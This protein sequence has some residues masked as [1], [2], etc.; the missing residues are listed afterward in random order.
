MEQAYHL[1]V[2]Q[3]FLKVKHDAYFDKV[4]SKYRKRIV[5][6]ED[7][8]FSE[9]GNEVFLK[10]ID[11]LANALF[12]EE[13]AKWNEYIQPIL[14]S[15]DCIV[16]PKSVD[17]TTELKNDSKDCAHKN[18]TIILNRIKRNP[19]IDRLQFYIDM[20]T[21]GF[22]LGMLWVLLLGIELDKTFGDHSYGNRIRKSVKNRNNACDWK[23]YTF[24]PY[25]SQYEKWRDG[26]LDVAQRIMRKEKKDVAVVLL[27]IKS[28]FYNIDMQKC[29]WDNLYKVTVEP[30]SSSV[31]DAKTRRALKRLHG[32]VRQVT[33]EYS[34]KIIYAQRSE[35]CDSSSLRTML[36]IGFYPS[37]IISNWCLDAFDNKIN[38]I[39]NPAFYGRYVDDMVVVEKV[40]PNSDIDSM[41]KKLDTNNIEDANAARLIE[42]LFARG[43]YRLLQRSDRETSCSEFVLRHDCLNAKGSR[44]VVQEDK[45][46]LLYFDHEYP[47]ALIDEFRSTIARNTSMFKLMPMVR[48]EDLK[49]SFSRI[50]D[51]KNDGS[52]NKLRDVSK[53]GIDSYELSKFLGQ[54]QR[55]IP[56]INKGLPDSIAKDI[57]GLLDDSSLIQHYALW[58][59]MLCVLLL[60]GDMH[61]LVA[62]VERIVSAI[63]KIRFRPREGSIPL[64]LS[65]WSDSDSS[66]AF[67]MQEA[68]AD[69]LFCSLVRVFSLSEGEVVEETL[70]RIIQ[71]GSNVHLPTLRPEY[72][73]KIW[74]KRLSR[75][76]RSTFMTD[77]YITAVPTMLIIPM[78]CNGVDAAV[79]QGSLASLDDSYRLLGDVCSGDADGKVFPEFDIPLYG[80]QSLRNIASSS[81]DWNAEFDGYMPLYPYVVKPYDLVTSIYHWHISHGQ[82]LPY[83]VCVH[84][85]AH[86]FL[87]SIKH[88]KYRAE[89][90]PATSRGSTG[91]YSR[92]VSAVQFDSPKVGAGTV[93]CFVQI[94]DSDP[95]D[96]NT[97][98]LALA[99]M[100]L[101]KSDIESN[102]QNDANRSLKRYENIRL[103]LAA[104]AKHKAHLVLMPELAVPIEWLDLVAGYSMREGIAVVCGVE[105]AIS[106]SGTKPVGYNLT[107]VLL[108]YVRDNFPYVSLTFHSKVYW[109]EL[110]SNLFSNYSVTRIKGNSFDLFRW[111][112]VWFP[113]YCCLELSSISDRSRFMAYADLV[114]ACEWNKDTNYSAHIL[115]SLARDLQ[116]YCAQANNSIYGD[117]RIVRPSKSVLSDIVRVK[118]GTNQTVI[119]GELNIDTI[120]HAQMGKR[121][122]LK[123]TPPGFNKGLARKK[124]EGTLADIVFQMSGR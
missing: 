68:L 33:M 104:A 48:S 74:H 22:I 32:F 24:E 3:A 98:K 19:V 42:M 123:A 59:R 73:E 88:C 109:A 108:P 105:H 37:Q 4:R 45:V 114:L 8:R 10:K 13:D 79:W 95:I 67:C 115:Q 36:P 75:L 111:R 106:R 102:L 28:F 117:S 100:Q 9:K 1:T 120:R 99:N 62:F 70:D 50:Y 103:L 124:H 107:A 26:A 57:V 84:D 52:P 122:E 94:N 116:C 51:L 80:G 6:F 23:P 56:V 72:M 27:D 18:A 64:H 118:G 91:Y 38:S 53:I 35:V 60:L 93:S 113:V 81:V 54:L 92:E 97:L 41:L 63:A 14:E 44:L 47:D 110:E 40:E 15:V 71:C 58:E 39:I 86:K 101:N 66:T 85:L 46:R 119:I 31:V 61:H 112:D 96:D 16:L 78:L 20:S 43:D 90:P 77:K 25:F 55:I 49:G 87:L 5:E 17:T 83:S 2:L 21:E 82:P 89:E 65:H 76:F 69:I 34:R 29:D 12:I 30:V 11:D 7:N 121:D